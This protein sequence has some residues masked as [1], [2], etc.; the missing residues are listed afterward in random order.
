MKRFNTEIGVGLFMVIGF[1]CIAW[2]A[3]RLGDIHVFAEKNYPLAAHFTS[4]AGLK[5]GATVEIAGVQ[6]GTVADISLDQ[7]YYEAVVHM[8]IAGNVQIQEDSIASIRTT[9]IIGQKFISISPGGAPEFLKPGGTIV[10][11][12]SSLSLEELISKYI[13]EGK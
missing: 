5:K 3:V 7:E 12:E 1:A 8:N 11:T 10:E 9:G 6:I 13:F 2:M 4:V